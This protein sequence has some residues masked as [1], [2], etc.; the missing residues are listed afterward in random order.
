MKRLLSLFLCIILIL[1]L[2]CSVFAANGDELRFNDDGSFKILLVADTQDTNHPQK[3]MLRLL[4]ACLD[5]SN[6]DLVIF[7]GDQI[8][9]PSMGKSER[10]VMAAIDAI[11]EPVEA[12]GIPFAVVFGNHDDEGGVSKEFQMAY[13]QTFDGCLAVAGEQDITGVGNYNLTIRS[14]DSKKDVV[15][16]WFF[17]SGTYDETGE[18]KYAWVEKDQLDWYEKTSNAL[19]E[20]NAGE[21]LPSYAFQHIIVP[22]AY[23]MLTAVPKDTKDAVEGVSSHE[24]NY[25]ILNPEYISSGDMGEAPCPPALNGGQFDA[26]E[27]QGDV[28]AAFFGHDHVNDFIGTYKGIDLVMTQGIGFYIYGK[29]DEHGARVLTLKEDT[30]TEYETELLFYKDLV[31]EPLPPLFASTNG[32]FIQNA[33]LLAILALAVLISTAVVLIKHAKRKKKQATTNK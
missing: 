6:P 2:C 30:P 19:A 16:L 22:E 13:Y 7:L 15:N 10:A 28:V 17:D 11:I 29:G 27:R 3:A 33:V 31:S 25:Y 32:A 9:G 8:H 4:N 21:L 26:W 24:G 14:S 18:G 20:T 23:E 5:K 1:S 12:R